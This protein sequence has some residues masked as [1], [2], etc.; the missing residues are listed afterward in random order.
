MPSHIEQIIKKLTN[1]TSTPT[2]L[3]FPCS[4][5]NK[6]VLANQKSLQ[7]DLCNTWTHI[8]CDGTPEL[9]SQMISNNNLSWECLLCSVS[10][11]RANI[12]FTFCDNAEI[13]NINSSNSMKFSESLPEL[14]IS[15]EASK[16]SNLQAY[17]LDLNMANL[18]DCKYYTVNEFH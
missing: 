1:V 18:N 7:C 2:H 10:F 17:D 6:N 16:F 8:K 15:T 11:N 12:P 5:C 4:I 13:I 14:E 9:Y 3:T